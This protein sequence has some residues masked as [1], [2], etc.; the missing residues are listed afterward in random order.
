MSRRTRLPRF[1]RSGED[2]MKPSAYRPFQFERATYTDYIKWA[3]ESI[4][5]GR[6]NL[7]LHSP[8]FLQKCIEANTPAESFPK[9]S[10]RHG[11]LLIHGLMSS[12]MGMSSLY[13]YF[14]EKNYLVRSVLLPGHGTRPGDLLDVTYQ[15]WLETCRFAIKTLKK[16]VDHVSV[17]AFSAGSALAVYLSLTERSLINSLVLLAPAISLKHP[18]SAL[19]AE[20]LYPFRKILSLSKM[21]W[22]ILKI[23]DDYAKY[24]SIPINAIYQ[25]TRLIK[26]IQL[27]NHTLDIPI[28]FV[29]TKDDETISHEKAVN[30]FIKQTHSL[31]R[32]I[33]YS[34]D[35]DTN[36]PSSLKCRTSHY[37]QD[38]ILDFSHTSLAIS[39]EHP[40]YGKKGDYADFSHYS[41]TKRMEATHRTIY[42]GS[43]SRKNLRKYFIQRLSYNPDFDYLAAD[44]E[45]FLEE[46]FSHGKTS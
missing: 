18:L 35:L 16:E 4:K 26:N 9:P 32:G 41:P 34:T 12:P 2:F 38:N 21:N 3:K 44:I 30:F 45:H 22:P 23:E 24:H 31:N 36:L 6:A 13:Q 27:L 29:S 11:I 7:D 14:S 39:A 46:C 17:I 5:T 25:I 33:I 28:Y 19:Y 8:E 10:T 15:D 37:P 1:F 20:A 42:Y 40:H 43:T